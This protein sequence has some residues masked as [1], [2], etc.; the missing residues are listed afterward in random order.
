MNMPIAYCELLSLGEDRP[1]STE[2]VM[3]PQH[4]LRLAYRIN[5]PSLVGDCPRPNTCLSLHLPSMLQLRNLVLL[6]AAISKGV[7]A[8]VVSVDFPIVNEEI[9]P[10][11]FLRV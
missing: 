7:A 8:A 1:T 5:R 9:A 2:E 11:G 6:F 3:S 4:R 10:D